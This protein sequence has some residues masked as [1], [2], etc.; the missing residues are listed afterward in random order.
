MGI[1]RR[2]PRSIPRGPMISVPLSEYMLLFL[3]HK[4]HSAAL[5]QVPAEESAPLSAAEPSTQ[6]NPRAARSRPSPCRASA[7]CPLSGHPQGGERA[8]VRGGAKL[9]RES[10]SSCAEY[11]L[12]ERK[13]RCAPACR[14]DNDLRKQSPSRE[15]SRHDTC[16][17]NPLPEPR[18]ADAASRT[19]SVTR[20]AKHRPMPSATKTGARQHA[21]FVRRITLNWRHPGRGYLDRRDARLSYLPRRPMAPIPGIQ[22]G[23]GR[24]PT[25]L[26]AREGD[27]Y[28]GWFPWPRAGPVATGGAR[29]APPDRAHENRRTAR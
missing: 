4:L 19:A 9:I 3:Y 1:R 16:A 5:R 21:K 7:A 6:K 28:H 29:G 12:R 8:G 20:R 13:E 18:P 27:G 11:P 2:H 24:P 23:Y 26:V 10:S 17:G 14:A 25:P 15:K 22:G